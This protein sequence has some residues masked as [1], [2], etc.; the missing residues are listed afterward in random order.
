MYVTFK[1][2]I[3]DDFIFR[4]AGIAKHQAYLVP[5]PGRPN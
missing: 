1:I 4:I 5:K 3:F 2:E